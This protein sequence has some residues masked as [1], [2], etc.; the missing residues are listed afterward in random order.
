MAP[1]NWYLRHHICMTCSA[2]FWHIGLAAQSHG[3]S[4]TIS[5][6]GCSIMLNWIFSQCWPKRMGVRTV[7]WF[8]HSLLC[9]IK[10]SSNPWSL[11]GFFF[12]CVQ[13]ACFAANSEFMKFP[14]QSLSIS[15]QAD[16][17]LTLT[18]TQK[19]LV[20]SC[21]AAVNSL[22]CT[23]LRGFK[24]GVFRGLWPRGPSSFLN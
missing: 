15:S 9:F 16:W 11:K 18:Q 3:I 1:Y 6:P 14:V 19:L 17:L 12:T 24:I 10:V 21:A 23:L 4:R 2:W 5:L 22:W 7:S 13:I 8:T 20:S